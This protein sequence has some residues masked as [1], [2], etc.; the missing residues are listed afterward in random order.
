[1][2]AVVTNHAQPTPQATPEPTPFHSMGAFRDEEAVGSFMPSWVAKKVTRAK[3]QKDMLTDNHYYAKDVYAKKLSGDACVNN[4]AKDFKRAKA[5]ALKAIGKAHSSTEKDIKN[6]EKAKA[7]ADEASLKAQA[8]IEKAE[9]KLAS[10]EDTQ[11]SLES[12]TCGRV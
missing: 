10:I 9:Q 5:E 1:M 12:A 6:A 4:G 11:E 7:K 8:A 3:H 2:R